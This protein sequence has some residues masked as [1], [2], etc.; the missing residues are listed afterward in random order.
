MNHLQIIKDN[1]LTVYV[2]EEDLWVVIPDS[3]RT[4]SADQDG[5]TCTI[6][7]WLD[8]FKFIGNTLEEA[9]DKFNK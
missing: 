8:T 6:V 4:F 9:V 7:D 3:A 2:D 5:E 1:K